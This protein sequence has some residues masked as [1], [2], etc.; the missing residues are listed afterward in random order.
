MIDSCGTVHSCGQVDLVDMQS[1]PGGHHRFIMNYQDHLKEFCFIEP[2][3]SK[4]A[5]KVANNFLN[6]VFLVIGAP[7]VL[8]SGNGCEFTAA[9]LLK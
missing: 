7:H 1:M 8:Q 3:T 2:L 5:A 9:I 4:R 6:S